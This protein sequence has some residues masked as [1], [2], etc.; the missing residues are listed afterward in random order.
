MPVHLVLYLMCDSPLPGPCIKATWTANAL[1][2]QSHQSW[3]THPGTPVDRL[4]GH[5]RSEMTRSEI[6]ELLRSM[7]VA[8][9][10]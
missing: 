2:G 1:K 5:P 4:P 8:D 6:R 3:H 10:H 7:M 9:S